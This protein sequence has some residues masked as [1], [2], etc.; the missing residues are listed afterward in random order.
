[1]QILRQAEAQ[2]LRHQGHHANVALRS[3]TALYISQP[4]A[5]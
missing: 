1:L 5:S 3:E 4:Q 2:L